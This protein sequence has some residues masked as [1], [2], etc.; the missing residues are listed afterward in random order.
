M[1]KNVLNFAGMKKRGEKITY[2]TC[3]DYPMACLCEK[4]GYDM[5]LVGDS[6]GMVGYV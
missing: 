3:Y 2:L 4:A 1:K 5:L 6:L